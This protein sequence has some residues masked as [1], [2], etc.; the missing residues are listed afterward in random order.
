MNLE[1]A[2]YAK[3]TGDAGVQ[4]VLGNPARVSPLEGPELGLLPACYYELTGQGWFKTL[5]GYLNSNS[6]RMR[7]AVYGTYDDVKSAVS[8]L[9]AALKDWSGDQGG[10]LTVLGVF[11]E[12]GSDGI[13]PPI[14]ADE[15]G[16]C[17]TTLE[18]SITYSGGS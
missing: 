5:A 4:A 3:L 17:Y 13:D 16:V 10:G 11:P 14:H 6:S 1:Q 18:L 7:L 8:A 12:D 15:S 2:F 9:W